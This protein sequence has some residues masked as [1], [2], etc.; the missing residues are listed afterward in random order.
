MA[1]EMSSDWWIP[2]ALSHF[3]LLLGRNI[4]LSLPHHCCAVGTS[5]MSLEDYM[6]RD[7]GKLH[8]QKHPTQNHSPPDLDGADT[9]NWKQL[10]VW[11]DALIGWELWSTSENGRHLI[12]PWSFVLT[13]CWLWKR[14][15]WYTTC[16]CLQLT[17]WHLKSSSSQWA[18]QLLLAIW[19]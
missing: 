8:L 12:L 9:E 7:G 2:F 10:W 5:N 6:F 17:K 18:E 3:L 15:Y 16:L 14:E 19:L 13:V 4:Q 11:V 1:F